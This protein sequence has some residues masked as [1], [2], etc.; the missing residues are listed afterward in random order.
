MDF[1]AQIAQMTRI[2]DW[3]LIYCI[4][5]KKKLYMQGRE[6][7]ISVQKE[8]DPKNKKWEKKKQACEIVPKLLQKAVLVLRRIY[9]QKSRKN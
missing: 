4:K 7:S 2:L 1:W 8:K 9:V 6:W 3:N 5:K